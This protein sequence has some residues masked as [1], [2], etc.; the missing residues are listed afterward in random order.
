MA[1]TTNVAF[2]KGLLANLPEQELALIESG[3]KAKWDAAEQ[4]AIAAVVGKATDGKDADT[5]C[6]AKAYADDKMTEAL[7]WGSF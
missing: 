7:A 3:D 6:G 5:V 1:N 4:N 2:R